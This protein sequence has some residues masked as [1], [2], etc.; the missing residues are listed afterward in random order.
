MV[1]FAVNCLD[2]RFA[3]LAEIVCH[4]E[5]LPTFETVRNMLLLKESSFNDDSTSTTFKSSSSSP[6][7]L[8]ASSSSTTKARVLYASQ[9][10][11]LPSTFSTMSLQDLT[12]NMDTSATSHLNSH[13]HNLITIFNKRLFSSI[14]VGDGNSITVTN[15]RHS[16]IPSHHRP[17]HLHNVFVTLN[18][19]LNLISVRQ[20]PRDNNCTIEFDA[21]IFFVKDFL[22]LHILLRCDSSCDL[23]PVTKS[24]NLPVTFVST[25]SSTWHQRLGHPEDEVLRSLTS[26]HFISCNKEMSSHFC[27]TCQGK[28]VKLPFHSS[29]SIAQQPPTSPIGIPSPIEPLPARTHSMVTRSQSGIVK[30][31]ERLYL[32]TSNLSL[33]PK[34]SFIALKDPNWCNAMYD[35]YNALV[36]DG[37]WIL[38]PRSSNVN[39]VQSMW[40]F[41]H[42]FY[43][44]GTLSRYKAR[45]VANGSNEQ[46]GVDFDETF[47]LVVKPTTIRIVLCLVVSL[48]GLKQA[49]RAWFQR[50]A[51]YATR[52]G[53]SPSRFFS[54]LQQI[55][56]S[57]HKEFDMIDLGALN[58]FL[59]ISLVRHR[60]WLFLFL[61]KYA[62]QLWSHG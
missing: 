49:P 7:I 53:F 5:P 48:Y 18:I 22:S 31:I 36:K 11:S 41:K 47:S 8:M 62:L 33:I 56:D 15:T 55:V 20:F 42:K 43:V 39:L 38:V 40:L 37:T 32:H 29:D 54:R 50:F 2:S 21:F 27:H 16:I 4:R 14:H 28:H 25:S 13:A 24:S 30:P 9:L 10:T 51:G 59:G 12:W 46:H 35:E 34:S 17:L 1:I 6:T 23:Y 44:D 19:I 52:A 60:T 58:Y 45:L 26:H 3:T 61:K 57:I